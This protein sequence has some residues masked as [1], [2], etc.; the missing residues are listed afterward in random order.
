MRS[1]PQEADALWAVTDISV[2]RMLTDLRG[3][4]AEQYQDWIADTI[5]RLV[6]DGSAQA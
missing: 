3:W 2:Y 4:T 1:P 5:A 6:D